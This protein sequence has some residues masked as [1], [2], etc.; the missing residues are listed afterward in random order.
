M[1]KFSYLAPI[2]RYVKSKQPVAQMT[3]KPT[4]KKGAWDRNA[5]RLTLGVGLAVSAVPLFVPV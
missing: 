1:S 3:L 4:Q 2:A 5:A